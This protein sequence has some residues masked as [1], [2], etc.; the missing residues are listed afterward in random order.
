VF[1]CAAFLTHFSAA[2][3]A[4]VRHRSLLKNTALLRA[5]S[6]LLAIPPAPFR[7]FSDPFASAALLSQREKVSREKGKPARSDRFK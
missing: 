3:Q 6:S 7:A 5:P 2:I 1:L 4:Q